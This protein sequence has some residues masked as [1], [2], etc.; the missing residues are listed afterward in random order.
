[1]ELPIIDIGWTMNVFKAVVCSY[2][3]LLFAWWGWRENK[4][5]GKKQSPVYNCVTFILLGL[6]IDNFAEAYVRYEWMNYLMDLR[7][8]WWWPMRLVISTFFICLLVGTLQ[9]RALKAI[10]EE[11]NGK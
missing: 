10:K 8:A 1:M 2:G 5:A 7:K 4:R 3:F 6:A 11:V 9:L